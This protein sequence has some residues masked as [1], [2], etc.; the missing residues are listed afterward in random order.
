MYKVWSETSSNFVE[1]DVLLTNNSS[2]STAKARLNKAQQD[3]SWAHLNSLGT[4]GA[5]IKVVNSEIEK[6]DIA[7]WTRVLESSASI[8]Y[9]FAHKSLT[10]VLPTAANLARWKITSDP[11]CPLC[12][13]NQPQTNKHVLANCSSPVALTRYTERHNEVLQIL[14]MWIKSVTSPNQQVLADLKDANNLSTSSLFKNLRPDIA[15]CDDRS[16]KVLELTICHETNLQK[17]KAFKLNKY[18]NL[19]DDASEMIRGKEIS[20]FTIEI[21]ESTSIDPPSSDPPSI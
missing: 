14:Y 18:R 4:Q 15:V 5:S 11:N 10:Q 1:S 20:C 9:N 17:S 6:K 3:K 8:I 21:S 7:L 19:A 12:K 16:V 2:L 13:I